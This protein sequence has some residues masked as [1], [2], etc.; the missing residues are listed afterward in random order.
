MQT[1]SVWSFFKLASRLVGAVIAVRL[2]VEKP[3]V[4]DKADGETRTKHANSLTFGARRLGEGLT[5]FTLLS[6]VKFD[7][8]GFGKTTTTTTVALTA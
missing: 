5:L 8:G 7:D 1:K 6:I 3:P 4:P 2:A